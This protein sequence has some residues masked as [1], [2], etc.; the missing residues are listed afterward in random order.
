M[1]TIVEAPAYS[2]KAD[3]LLSDDERESVVA[4]VA[5]NPMAGSVIP[6]SGGVRKLRWR[7]AHGGKRGGY[8]MIYFNR[9]ERG[10]VWLLTIYSK[11]QHENISTRD[12]VQIRKAIDD[13]V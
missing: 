6:G 8:R 4:F 7:T 5:M 2:R 10:Q 11:R 9:L 12:L 13:D 3:L 1:Y